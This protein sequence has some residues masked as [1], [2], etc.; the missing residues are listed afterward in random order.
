MTVMKL[1]LPL[2]ILAVLATPLALR[3]RGEAPPHTNARALV[4][5]T[6][7]TMSVRQEVARAFVRDHQRRTGEEVRIDW[8]TPGGTSEITRYLSS[9]YIAAF[10]HYW[11]TTLHRAW[12]DEVERGFSDSRLPVA[13]D[14]A[15]ETPPQA[16]RREFLASN[17]GCGIDLFFGGGSFDSIQQASAG[18]LVDCG[19]LKAHPEWFGAGPGAIPQTFGGEPYWDAGGRW[20]GVCVSA[21]GICYNRDGLRRLGID[22]APRRWADLADPR[23]AH[24]LALANPTQSGSVN[25]AFEMLIQQ[26]ILEELPAHPG[27]EPAAVRAGWSKAMRLLLRIGANARYF[28]DAASKIVLDVAAGESAAGMS[29]DFYGQF[30]ADA[31]RAPDGASRMGY[32]NAVGGTSFGADPVGLLRGAPQPELAREFIEWLL[33]PEGQ[34]LWNGKVGTPGGPERYALRRLPLSPLLYRPEFRSVRS[35]PEIDPYAPGAAFVY[36]GSWTGPLF[37]PIAFIVRAM[38]MDP[39]DELT[40]A[41]REIIAAGQPPEAVAALTDVDAVDYAAAQG[42]IRA[43]L[44]TGKIAEVELA[45]QLSE[46]FRAQYLRATA[47]A[48]QRR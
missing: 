40:E 34:K 47:L 14:P 39:H 11:V 32:V 10:Q 2:A 5:I 27:D 38:C 21:F 43:T 6:P 33:S 35:D 45:R 31:V 41:W 48:R 3:R 30:E 18:R 16:A 9:E 12:S 28:T 19:I 20:V 22:T 15:H 36:H 24:Q 26:Q 23:Y 25:K 46:H 13:K 44:A 17:V 29:I 4:I 7:N 42:R 37:R 1:A 8:R